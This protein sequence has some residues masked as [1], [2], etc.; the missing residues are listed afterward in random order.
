MKIKLTA[1]ICV[2]IFLLAGCGG[3]SGETAIKTT[4]TP[5]TEVVETTVATTA[6]TEPTEPKTFFEEQGFHFWANTMTQQE[7][8]LHG[9]TGF[10]ATG[11]FPAA[12]EAYVSISTEGKGSTAYSLCGVETQVQVHEYDLSED[13]IDLPQVFSST[14][15]VD[16]LACFLGS[17]SES[18][19]TLEQWTEKYD[20]YKLIWCQCVRD[21]QTANL[22]N[23]NLSGVTGKYSWE[24]KL[25]GE[26]LALMNCA[27]GTVYERSEEPYNE[28]G[29]FSAINHNGTSEMRMVYDFCI[30]EKKAG[31]RPN[32]VVSENM[33]I[34]VPEDCNELAFVLPLVKERRTA[35]EFM[36]Q[37]NRP[38]EEGVWKEMSFAEY[39][40]SNDHLAYYFFPATN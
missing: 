16:V 38:N 39:T 20:D 18:E 8:S 7:T 2:L 23:S 9:G 15:I 12:A 17:E 11:Y 21:N 28:I 3:D 33:Y 22:V 32:F 35:G 10:Q 4:V 25:I 24:L 36:E 5:A 14:D 1:L 29:V 26:R 34:L 6:A 40:D 19:M 37:Y 27:D 30:T 31:E 13:T